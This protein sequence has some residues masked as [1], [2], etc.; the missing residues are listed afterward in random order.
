MDNGTKKWAREGTE[1][2]KDPE[3]LMWRNGKWVPYVA[4]YVDISGTTIEPRTNGNHK[5]T[6]EERDNLELR[7]SFDNFGHKDQ[8]EDHELSQS[9]VLAGTDA[10]G[11]IRMPGQDEDGMINGRFL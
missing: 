2:K 3:F 9:E 1:Q 6:K 10:D 5:P 4:G 11:V 7:G 8:L